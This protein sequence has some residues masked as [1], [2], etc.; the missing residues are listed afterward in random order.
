M[1]S[2]RH[3]E[4]LQVDTHFRYSSSHFAVQA[5]LKSKSLKKSYLNV[6]I[7]QMTYGQLGSTR[8]DV[9]ASDSLKIVQTSND[10][11]ILYEL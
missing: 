11:L 5:K 3:S 8:T 7:I 4:E 10:S 1:Q 2:M 9:E 6:K